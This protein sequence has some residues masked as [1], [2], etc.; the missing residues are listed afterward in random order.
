VISDPVATESPVNAESEAGESEA[1][2]QE[3]SSINMPKIGSKINDLFTK[4]KFI[5]LSNLLLNK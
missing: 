4:R 2:E 3:T 1:G 5:F